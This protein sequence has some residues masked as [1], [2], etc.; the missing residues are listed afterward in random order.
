MCWNVTCSVTVTVLCK[1]KKAG[2]WKW[3]LQWPEIFFYSKIVLDAG[4]LTCK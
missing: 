2:V 3:L 4:S 1:C